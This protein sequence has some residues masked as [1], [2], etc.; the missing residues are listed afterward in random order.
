MN[1][2]G[3]GVAQSIGSLEG[4]DIHLEISL[5]PRSIPLFYRECY[6]ML[7]Q[8]GS[9]HRNAHVWNTASITGN[10]AEA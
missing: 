10:R 6:A 8:A 3:V 5:K 7:K 1:N 2:A 9:E 4:D